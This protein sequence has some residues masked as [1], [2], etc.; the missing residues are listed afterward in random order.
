MKKGDLI[1][2]TISKYVFPNKGSFMHTEVNPQT[3]EEVTRS[4]STKGKG[5]LPGAEVEVRIKKKRADHADGILQRV[6]KESDLEACKPVCT[7]YYQC[8]GCTYQTVPYEKQLELKENLV[9]DLLQEY[10]DKTPD[11]KWDGILPSPS[12]FCYKNKMEFTFG[13]AEQYGPMTLG[14]HRQGSTYDILAIET[15]AIVRPVWNEIVKYTQKFYREKKVDF[16]HK[17]KHQGF[18]RNL[19]IRQAASDGGILVNL[20]TT[21]RADLNEPARANGISE[22]NAVLCLDEWVKGLVALFESDKIHSLEGHNRLA[23]VLHTENDSFADAIIPQRVKKLYGD[24]FLM[25]EVLGL[26]F[27]I[28]PFSFFQTNTRGAEVLYDRVREYAMGVYGLDKKGQSIAENDEAVK[29]EQTAEKTEDEK[30]VGTI[31]DL[32]SGTGTIAQL[33]APIA[34]KVVGIEIIEE[35]VES[36]KVNAGINRL[37][38]CEFIAGDVLK[39]LDEVEE[40]P[41]FIILDPPRDG[42]NPKA[43]AKILDYGVDNI[44]YISCKP[45]S[46]QRDLEAFY[47]A[48]YKLV[49]GSCVDNFCHTV[50]VETVCLLSNTQKK[51]E[52]YVTLD[53]EM[54]DY[55]RI[56]GD[57]KTSDKP[58]GK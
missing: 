51:K 39:K 25:E 41:D 50:H 44:I 46:L 53:V 57:R 11:F 48:G 9:K 32:Y 38:N 15:C 37:K 49:R 19:V 35:A 55:H 26:E 56:V 33:M 28:S 17:M 27:K 40:K 12:P 18:L 21:T 10:I 4:I 1:Q 16:Y 42:C 36:A 7:H 54:K 58:A 24:D 43:L 3:G 14:L 20:V 30:P 45:T 6:I 22:A 13:D 8:G 5:V 2:G 52:S 34:K 23:G 47:D 31:F 29:D